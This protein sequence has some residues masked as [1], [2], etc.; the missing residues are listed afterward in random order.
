MDTI[1]AV[2]NLLVVPFWFLMIV[3]PHWRWTQRAVQSPL[4]LLP[5]LLLYAALALPQLGEF[6]PVLF[7][8]QLNKVAAALGQPEVAAVG[9]IHYLAF[10]LFVGRYAFL[11]SRERGISAWLMAPVLLLTLFLGPIGLLV[12]LGIQAFSRG[13]ENASLLPVSR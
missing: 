5:F 1:F 9:W 11:D 12:Y 6:W 10:D 2:S 3:L 7:N 4:I 13:P 8:P